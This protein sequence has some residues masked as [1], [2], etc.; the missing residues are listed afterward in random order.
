MNPIMVMVRLV[1][2]FGVKVKNVI[3]NLLATIVW[4]LVYISEDH[5]ISGYGQPMA[6]N[7][8]SIGCVDREVVK[9][10]M[11][12][13]KEIDQESANE[14]EKLNTCHN[15]Q[16]IISN[17]V[18]YSL[19][20]RENFEDALLIL[21]SQQGDR[22]DNMF[23]LFLELVETVPAIKWRVEE[24]WGRSA[25]LTILRIF[26]EGECL[27]LALSTWKNKDK[28]RDQCAFQTLLHWIGMMIDCDYELILDVGS[29]A[30][31]DQAPP[32]FQ[33]RCNNKH[34]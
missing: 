26:F 19:H 6:S 16:G 22:A 8:Q 29:R 4:W 32:T 27:Y 28:A 11:K 33:W 12:I 2:R 30:I 3:D 13:W 5:P 34:E 9:S 18:R 14:K 15:C 7:D 17:K 23:C 20:I 24:G 21:L 10:I 31:G 1:I 25:P